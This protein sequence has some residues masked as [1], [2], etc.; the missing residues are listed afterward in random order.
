MLEIITKIMRAIC[1]CQDETLLKEIA[2]LKKEKEIIEPKTLGTITFSDANKILSPLAENIFLS[3]DF[4]Q[5]T[6]INEAKIFVQDTQVN[7]EQW[8]TSHDC[9]NFSFALM[10]Y[11]S[12]GLKSFAFGIAWSSKHAFNIMIDNNKQVWIV[13]PQTTKFMTLEEAKN[14]SMYFPLRLIVM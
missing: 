13:E 3:D 7:A 11:W 2:E 12:E 1:G 14:D 4:Y 8:T 9:D 10:G 5:L 6:D